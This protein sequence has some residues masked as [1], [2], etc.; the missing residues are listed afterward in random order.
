MIF[1][2]FLIGLF[3]GSFLNCVIYRLDKGK[4]FVKGRSY[5]PKC[6][7]TLSWNDLIP[8]FSFLFLKGR[9]R[10]CKEKISMQ[11]PIIELITGILFAVVYFY[12]SYNPYL[13]IGYLIITS[14]FVVV[15]VFDLLYFLVPS[16]YVYGGVFVIL[17]MHLLMFM[18]GNG[19][20]LSLFFNYLSPYLIG[21]LIP[22]LFFGGL[23]VI[24]KGKWMGFGDAEIGLL[25]GIVLGWQ[26]VLISLL[27]A[28]FLGA[29]IGV[30]MIILKKKGLKS[31]IPF[32]PFLII[33]FYTALLFGQELILFYKYYGI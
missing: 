2:I 29:I 6:K 32:G 33:G 18:E 26:R 19:F 14:I 20:D 15:F 5:C 13:L 1:F 9:C 27:L 11:Y 28:V 24:S 31:E 7:H 17:I 4:S 25:M 10:Y 8:V 16:D 30:I 23:H 12:F 3:I 21:A 22:F